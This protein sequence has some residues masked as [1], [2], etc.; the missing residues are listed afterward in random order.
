[1]G[2]RSD[3]KKQEKMGH[4][5]GGYK[6]ILN[7]AEK[8][9]KKLGVRVYL[10]A[11]VK[12]IEVN[13]SKTTSSK[14]DTERRGYGLKVI[15]D[16]SRC[17]F[18]KV[19]LTVNCPT[20]VGILGGRNGNPHWN[21]IREVKYLGVICCL[22]ILKRQLSPYYVINLLDKALPFTGIIE[23]TNIVAPKV[24]QDRHLVYLPK[25]VTPDDAT[26][27]LNDEEI[28]ERFI[29]GVRKVFPDLRDDEIIHWNVFREQY[30]QPLQ[31]LHYLDR[32]V[33]PETP[34]EDLYLVNTSMIYNS[35]LN[36]NAAITTAKKAVQAIVESLAE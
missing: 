4:I 7:A 12:R 22:L 17:W 5:H 19:L 33:G 6:A 25:Y 26:H 24:V 21:N 27:R 36:N 35:T 15:A 18:D 31:E 28:A 2:A 29:D 23:A 30:V 11:P 1:Y 8:R 3:D 14:T 34:I 13:D 20:V 16:H 32:K 10:H 9:L